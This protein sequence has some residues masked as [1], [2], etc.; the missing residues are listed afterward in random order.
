MSKVSFKEKLGYSVG[1]IGGTI[2]WQGMMFFLAIFYTDVFGLPAT[3][4]GFLMFLPRFL[5]AFVDPVAGIISDRTKTRWGKFRP[6]L[7][8]M[9]L[10]YA[11]M[12]VLM[13]LTPNFEL[14]GKIIYAYITY[15]L[16]MIIYSFI[17]IPF[18]ALGG[19]ISNDHIERTSIQ[20]IRF[21]MAFVGAI[22]IRGVTMPLAS[23]LGGGYNQQ[24]NLPNNAQ[25]G[26]LYTMIIFAVLSLVLFIVSFATTK[27]RVVPT[28]KQKSTLKEDL[29]DL[30]SNKP[31]LALFITSVFNLIWV[32]IWST[33]TAYYFKYFVTV[34]TLNI[35]GFDTGY[36]LFSTFNVFSSIVII[37]VLISPIPKFLI[38]LMGKRNALFACLLV[39]AISIIGFYFARPEDALFLMILQFGQS[40]A[41]ASTMPIIW[42]MYADAA[43]YSEWKNNRRATGLVYSAVVFG[44][45]IGV[46]LGAAVPLWILGSL[47]Y[48]DKTPV[49][50]DSIVSS[51]RLCM[52]IL[53]GVFVLLTALFCLFYKLTDKKMDQIQSELI[54]RRKLA[55][56]QIN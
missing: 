39:V 54:E 7:L 41:A 45:K 3:V 28:E 51:I 27:E 6:Y 25:Q 24:T 11:I 31:W 22:I 12:M 14:T 56:E 18:N 26:F 37:L 43:D 47:N 49:Q 20:S 1:E 36:D 42:S 13:Y 29:K 34:R 23:A 32:G 15:T 2:S 35:F 8:W 53:P 33:S 5:D 38:K 21:S 19:V 50:P 30:T 44:Q 52:S 48:S 17:M 55:M 40:V 46:A 4:A 10:P 16:M 9:S